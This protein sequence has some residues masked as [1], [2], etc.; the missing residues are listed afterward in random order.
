MVYFQEAD[1]R[2]P[3]ARRSQKFLSQLA[4][5]LKRPHSIPEIERKRTGAIL[6]GA[7]K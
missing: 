5:A 1:R 4:L 6:S 2:A 7:F 3:G